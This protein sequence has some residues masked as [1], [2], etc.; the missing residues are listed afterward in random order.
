[1]RQNRVCVMQHN[2]SLTLLRELGRQRLSHPTSA[3]ISQLNRCWA[4]EE[5][6]LGWIYFFLK[7][8]V[9]KLFLSLVVIPLLQMHFF[10]LINLPCMPVTKQSWIQS[11]GCRRTSCSAEAIIS[12]HRWAIIYIRSSTGRG[13][14]Q[15]SLPCVF[16]SRLQILEIL[17][18]I[19]NHNCFIFNNLHWSGDSLSIL[20]SY[21]VLL[22]ILVIHLHR[23]ILACRKCVWKKEN[24]KL[25]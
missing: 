6:K 3:M 20:N 15:H 14:P 13:K 22:L 21:L 2:Y 4:V 11:V 5:H 8:K 9:W 17:L 19:Y 16:P 18:D 12:S 7:L 10:F 1:M 25:G 24:E 23:S